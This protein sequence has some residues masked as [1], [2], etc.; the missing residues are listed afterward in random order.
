M[1]MLLVSASLLAHDLYLMP[2]S[3]IVKPGQSLKV[4]VN[5][6][7]AFPN[8]EQSPILERLQD[9]ELRSQKSVSKVHNLRIVGEAAVGEVVVPQG[10]NLV[11]SV[12]TIPNLI[13]LPPREFA[14][15]LEE[16]GLTQIITWRAQHNESDKPGRERYSKFAKSLLLGN[17]PDDFSQKPLGSVIE[18]VPLANP[19]RLHAGDSLPV[20][21]LL[22]GKPAADLQLE[23]T[24]ASSDTKTSVVGR[25]NA[26]GE[27]KVPLSATG[28]WRLH[29]VSMERSS[30]S[31]AA[32]W[33]SFWASLTFEIR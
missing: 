3:F 29:T 32:D 11:L 26:K 25:T 13:E 5:N 28:K 15:Y 1:V 22:R 17:K 30:D 18:I 16:E 33:E 4:S 27:I 23:A 12:R 14:E 31:T 8:S 24:Y 6:G 19:Y 9:A 21:I 2:G 20:R 7:D 10:G